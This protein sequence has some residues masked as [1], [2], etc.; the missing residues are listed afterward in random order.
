[1]FISNAMNVILLPINNGYLKNVGPYLC[2][3]IIEIAYDKVTHL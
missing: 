2:F 1:M 3:R